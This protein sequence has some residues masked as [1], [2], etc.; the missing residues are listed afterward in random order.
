MKPKINYSTYLNILDF[1]NIPMCE[2]NDVDKK[3]QMIIKQ[4]I[5]FQKPEP[6]ANDLFFTIL[7]QLTNFIRNNISNINLITTC[8]PSITVLFYNKDNMIVDDIVD[9]NFYRYEL[10]ATDIENFKVNNDLNTIFESIFL[11]KNILF[12]SMFIASAEDKKYL[13][14]LYRYLEQNN[15]IDYYSNLKMDDFEIIDDTTTEDNKLPQFDNFFKN[16]IN[17][18]KNNE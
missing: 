12:H 6:E 16:K 17:S 10:D 14:F 4:S 5:G 8:K 13:Y 9:C 11:N 7:N 15:Y 18:I 1:K 2:F 3:I